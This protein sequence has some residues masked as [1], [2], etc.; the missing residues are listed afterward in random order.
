MPVEA[1]HSDGFGPGEGQRGVTRSSWR[2]GYGRGPQSEGKALP[3]NSSGDGVCHLR[4]KR[5]ND[6]PHSERQ[7]PA[8]TGLPAEL[9]RFLATTRHVLRPLAKRRQMR[10]MLLANRLSRLSAWTAVSFPSWT[11][12]VR[13][14]SPASVSTGI[15]RSQ[16]ALTPCEIRGL[17]PAVFSAPSR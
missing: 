7:L 17:G 9:P 16:L 5:R 1:K 4:K 12:S 14:R 3:G 11:S 8:S 15:S 2:Q 13:I 6:A 10:K